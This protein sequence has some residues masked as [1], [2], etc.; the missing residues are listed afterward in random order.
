MVH[1]AVEHARALGLSLTVDV[2]VLELLR[3]RVMRKAI[4]FTELR[5]WFAAHLVPIPRRP[6]PP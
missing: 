2:A 4:D 1:F 3:A 6:W 5:D